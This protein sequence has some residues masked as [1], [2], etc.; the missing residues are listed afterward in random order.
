MRKIIHCDADCFYAAIEMRDNP[1]LLGKPVA[2]GGDARRRGVIATCNYE[3][4]KFG[5][6]SAMPTNRALALCPSL[7]LITPRM[8]A[9]REASLQ[10]RE[11][12]QDYT[13]KIEP[14][15]LDE[16][17]LD[18]SDC[19]RHK[20]SAT[21]IAEEIRARIKASVNITVSAGVAPNKM[22][23]K[24]ASDWNKPDGLFVITPSQI[25]DFVK[26]LP[27]KKIHGVGK[28][29]AEKLAALNIHTCA[30]LQTWTVF[31][32]TKKLGSFGARLFELS[33][34]IDY[35]EVNGNRRRKSVSVENTFSQDLH[36][37][38][39]CF[40]E[41]PN[42]LKKLELRLSRLDNSYQI[43]KLFVKVKFTDFT[44][45]TMERSG[46]LLDEAAYRELLETAYH[47]KHIAVRLLGV[48]VTFID[49]DQ[50]VISQLSLFDDNA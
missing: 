14:L 49:R 6:H 32:L 43:N 37:L 26:E 35:R 44:A 10:M 16:A 22:L 4:R 39:A 17:Y 29:L 21:L 46:T 45:T 13:D 11:I 9:Y 7:I 20:G 36:S 34:G 3:A 5:I 25:D 15:S 18:V 41:L 24:I 2:V 8:E 47:R 42:L 19:S 33:R 48:G 27:V 31:E 12:F 30:D 1:A 40:S 28:S 50:N 38:E 23:A